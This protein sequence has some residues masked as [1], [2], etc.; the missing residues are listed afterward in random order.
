MHLFENKF[1]VIMMRKLVK[2]LTRSEDE[3]PVK[4]IWTVYIVFI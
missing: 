1:S 4:S 2:R 3:P